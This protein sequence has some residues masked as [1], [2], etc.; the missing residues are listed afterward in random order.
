MKA[1]LALSLLFFASSALAAVVGKDGLRTMGLQTV[2]EDYAHIAEAVPS[3]FY[4]VGVTP[5][6]QDAASAPDNHSDLFYMDE[7]A[8]EVGLQTLLRVAVDY[9]ES[10]RPDPPSR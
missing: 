9:L 5:K 6:G 7:A 10:P 4:F 2:A 3:V 8:L 1:T